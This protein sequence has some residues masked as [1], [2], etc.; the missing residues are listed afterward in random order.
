M[1]I[2]KNDFYR[3][4][5]NDWKKYQRH[6]REGIFCIEEYNGELY[7]VDTYWGYLLNGV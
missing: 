1:K 2:K 7:L 3:Y 6:C 4:T 5:P